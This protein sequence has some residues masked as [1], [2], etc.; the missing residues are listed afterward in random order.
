MRGLPHLP[1]PCPRAPA[2]LGRE[3]VKGLLEG[4]GVV[5]PR[6]GQKLPRPP[7]PVRL[8][9][10]ERQR[11]PAQ[12]VGLSLQHRLQSVACVCRNAL[13]GLYPN[14]HNHRILV[15]KIAAWPARVKDSPKKA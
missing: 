10:R 6:E 9:L 8:V 4:A 7:H 11:L 5:P 2:D 1:R 15:P 12:E 14:H 3:Q 13:P